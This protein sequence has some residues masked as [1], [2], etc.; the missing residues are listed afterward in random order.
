MKKISLKSSILLAATL[1]SMAIQPITFAEDSS[2][3]SPQSEVKAPPYGREMTEAERK[4]AEAKIQQENDAKQKELN[5][6]IEK[7]IKAQTPAS[8]TGE[9]MEGNGTVV[10]FSTSGSKAFYTIRDENQKVFYLI[11]DLDKTDKNV[12]FLSDVNK[13]Q[14]ETTSSIP[15]KKT[16][17]KLETTSPQS[18]RTVEKKSSNTGFLLT[19][20]VIALGGAV[21][22]YFL[23][24]KPKGKKVSESD[25]EDDSAEDFIIEE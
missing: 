17:E 8:V 21:A 25:H 15:T 22:Y 20:I 10:D 9:K 7:E 3:S 11:I 23:I 2:T 24:V 14:L 5:N 18:T 6:A 4:E 13:E 19:I 16:N 12:Y 1:L